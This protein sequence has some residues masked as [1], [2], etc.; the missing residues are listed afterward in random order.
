M[1]CPMRF[2][3][4]L[5]LIAVA[6]NS[7][8]FAQED[9]SQSARVYRLTLQDGSEIV[10]T[11]LKEDSLQIEFRLVSKILLTVPRSQISTMRPLSGSIADGK[12]RRSDPNSTRLFF[13]PT[14]RPLKN[15]QGYFSAY[16]I[17]FPSLAVG[18]GDI[19]SLWGG[20]SLVPEAEGQLIYFA[21]KITPIHIRNFD[22]SAGVLYVNTT[23]G[24]YSGG[25]IIFGVGTYGTGDYAL[26]VGLGWGFAVSEVSDRPILVLGGEVRLSNSIKLISENWIPPWT[27]V[28]I[29]SFGFRFFGDNLAADLGFIRSSAKMETSGFP[30]VPW[31][32]FTY[33]FGAQ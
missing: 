29:F 18:I 8:A 19:V 26:T 3:M 13:S 27:D 4:L 2:A 11:I 22:L 20:V 5:I 14:G 21:P 25:G 24:S 15:G 1:G 30:F 17:F 16:E 31:I 7:A 28:A 10:G 33:N 12:Y 9:S 6:S 23:V 32:G